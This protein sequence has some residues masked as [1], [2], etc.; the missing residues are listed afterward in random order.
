MSFADKKLVLGGAGGHHRG[1]P[2]RTLSEISER[3]LTPMGYEVR[4][5][6][7]ASRN[8]SV[9]LMVSKEVDMGAT[10]ST[11]ARMAYQG[12]YEF[13]GEEPRTNLR[14]IAHI[15]HPS[16]LAVAVR[17]ESGITN[18]AQI[19]ERQLPVRVQGGTD[20]YA[21]RIWAHF[22]LSR[23]LIESWGGRFP[24]EPVTEPSGGVSPE[25]WVR[26]GDFDLI[27]GTIYAANTP[28]ARHWTECSVLFNLRFLELPEELNRELGEKIGGDPGFIPHR[29]VRGVDRDIPAMAREPQVIYGRDDMPEEFAYQLAKGLDEH[30]EYFRQTLIP[31]SYDPKTVAKEH[32][33]PLHPGAARYYREVGYP[34]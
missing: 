22:G 5:D 32:G 3:V 16:W 11:R 17:A 6:G 34:T 20:V 9:R 26:E 29:L 8:N 4:I 1:T 15:E 18:L 12:T 19:K 23:S 14:I 7:R 13:A 28:E 27:M 33:V 30:R 21:E 24:R 25:P 31:Y 2:W 10:H